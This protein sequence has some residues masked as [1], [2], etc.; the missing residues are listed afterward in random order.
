MKTI[1]SYGSDI[2]Q[3]IEYLDIRCLNIKDIDIETIE[4]YKKYLLR[5]GL[6]AKTVNRKLTSINQFLKFNNHQVKYKKLKEQKQN[7]LN[8]VLEKEE[9]EKMIYYCKDNIRDK[10]IMLTLFKMGLRV[11]ELLQ[12]VV[13]DTKGNK[14]TIKG[15]GGKYR[16][17]PVPKDVKK[18]WLEYLNIRKE[19]NTNK[20]FI[21]KRGALKRQSI[22]KIIQKYSRKAKIKKEKAH[23]HN[24]RHSFCKA[25]ASSGVDTLIIADLAGH[26]SLETTRIYTRQTEKELLNIMEMI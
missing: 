23:P 25:L 13:S 14:V 3:F 17:I 18:L 7:I 12:L 9:I 19:V 8:D 21:G 1:E 26:G 16:S 6:K 15:K 4:K 20:L 24:L 11:S 5:N 2:R 22:N 10:A